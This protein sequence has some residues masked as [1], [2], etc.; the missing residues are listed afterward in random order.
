MCSLL[1]KAAMVESCYGFLE[2][3][4]ENKPKGPLLSGDGSRKRELSLKRKTCH[5]LY[6]NSRKNDDFFPPRAKE[7]PEIKREL[8]RPDL[9]IDFDPEIV[10]SLHKQIF[11]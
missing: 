1:P 3:P 2:L 4:F 9:G 6:L 10:M 11:F 8:S 5:S 7:T